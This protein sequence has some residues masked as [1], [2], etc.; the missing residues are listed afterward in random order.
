MHYN[1]QNGNS[2]WKD[3]ID[4]DIEQ[5]KEYQV[6]KDHRKVVYDKSKVLN[7]PEEHQRL[8]FTLC[9]MSRIVETSRQ[10][11]AY[12]HLTKEPN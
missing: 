9:L 4:L 1:V 12:G 7:T 10:L 11:V 6:F 8:E 3:A 2:K 5:I